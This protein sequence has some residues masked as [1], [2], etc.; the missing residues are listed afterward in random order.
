MET[1][2][3]PKMA[4]SEEK[5]EDLSTR[6]WTGRVFLGYQLVAR[7]SRWINLKR[8][9]KAGVWVGGVTNK[10]WWK[11]QCLVRGKKE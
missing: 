3:G 5:E 2:K 9:G 4:A 1:R 7:T 8:T 11:N 10:V 6:A